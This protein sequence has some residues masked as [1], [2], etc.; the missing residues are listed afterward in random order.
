MRDREGK[1]AGVGG[2][3]RGEI[4]EGERDTERQT[5]RQT[6]RHR[7]TDREGADRRRRAHNGP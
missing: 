5:E 1:R 6:E 7:E 4:E 2:R 3:P